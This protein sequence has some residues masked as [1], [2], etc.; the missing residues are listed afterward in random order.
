MIGI[1]ETHE[2]GVAGSEGKSVPLFDGQGKDTA[3]NFG[4][5]LT[6]GADR[7]LDCFGRTKGRHADVDLRDARDFAQINGGRFG[8]EVDFASR[9]SVRLFAAPRTIR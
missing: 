7:N 5:V 2:T 6:I 9:K 3:A 4:K 1:S 8:K